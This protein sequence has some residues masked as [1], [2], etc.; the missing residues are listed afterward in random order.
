MAV[1]FGLGL[2]RL[3]EFIPKRKLSISVEFFDNTL[4]G[5]CPGRIPAHGNKLVGFVLFSLNEIR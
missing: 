2:I 4:P 3:V 5:I 1:K